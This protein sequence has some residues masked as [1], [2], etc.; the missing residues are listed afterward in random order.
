MSDDIDKEPDDINKEAD[1]ILKNKSK[2]LGGRPKGAR[3]KNARISPYTKAEAKAMYLAGHLPE[4]IA[5]A[6]KIPDASIISRWAR[7]D[8]WDDE[9]TRIMS[10]TSSGMLDNLLKSAMETFNGLQLIKDKSLDHL[11]DV[12]TRK[13]IAPTKYSEIVNAYI[14]AVDLE[15]KMKTNTLH[16][17]FI[18][19]VANVLKK[20]IQ[21]RQLLSDV[22]NDLVNVYEGYTQKSLPEPRK[23]NAD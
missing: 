8:K 21:D 6:I 2:N 20:R 3:D 14:A 5:A 11:K 1:E 10:S 7:E 4:D 9:R 12:G 17:R 16:A 22:L 23:D 18:A 13:G 15:Y 19:E